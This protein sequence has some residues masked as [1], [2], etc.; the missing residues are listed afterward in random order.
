MK[1]KSGTKSALPF[2]DKLVNSRGLS[3]SV[4]PTRNPIFR[5]GN[6]LDKFNQVFSDSL[7]RNN[8]VSGFNVVKFL[9]IL[10]DRKTS[11]IIAEYNRS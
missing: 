7:L 2:V 8:L 5:T 3:T 9:M 1:W 4:L 6:H 10:I 11:N